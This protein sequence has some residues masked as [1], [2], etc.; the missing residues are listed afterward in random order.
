MQSLDA[1]L[2]AAIAAIDRGSDSAAVGQLKAFVDEVTA[3]TGK[4]IT[5]AQAQ[6]LAGGAGTILSALTSSGV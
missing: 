2:N 4:T 6:V 1:K 3:Q 5:A